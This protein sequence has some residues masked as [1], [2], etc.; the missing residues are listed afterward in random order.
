MIASDRAALPEVLGD[1]AWL[2][3]PTEVAAL[4]DALERVLGDAALRARLRAAGP[5]RAARFSWR[6][7]ARETLAVYA[8]A[9]AE[10]REPR[11]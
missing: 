6:R 7:A 9:Y 4:T 2:C 8:Q 10:A 3:D 5:L 1:A 11:S